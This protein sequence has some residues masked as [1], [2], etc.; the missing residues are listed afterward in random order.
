VGA[1]AKIDT[2]GFVASTLNLSNED[3]AAGRLKF[4]NPNTGVAAAVQNYGD[5]TTATGGQVYLVGGNVENHGLITAPNGD[6]LLAAG[7]SVQIGD[8][9][10]PGVSIQVS[11]NETAANLGS[12]VAQSGKIG[13]VGALV[14]NS[15]RINADQVVHGADGKVYLKAKKD[16]T[17]EATSNIS[18][19][20]DQGGQIT[21]Q[22]EG[23]TA[24]VSGTV[25]AKGSNGTGGSI[26]ALGE[27]VGLTGASLNASGT[28]GGGTILMGGDAHGANAD[29]QNATATY[30]GA[31]STLKADATDSG[32]GGKVIVWADGTTRMYGAISARGGVNGGDGGFVETSGKSAL[33]VGLITPDAS[34]PLGTHGTWLLD[35]SDITIIHGTGTGALIAGLFDPLS[36]STIGDTQIN[37]AINSIV[38]PGID[39]IIKTA[40]GSGGSGNITVNSGVAI[41]NSN[42]GSRT[43]TLTADGAITIVNGSSMA[44]SAGNSLNVVLNATGG[45]TISGTINNAGGTTTLTGAAS[46]TGSG[47]IQNGTLLASTLNVSSGTLDTVTLGGTSMTV[48]GTLHVNNSLTLASGLTVTK[49]S[50]YW[51]FYGAGTEHLATTGSATINNPGGY[52]YANTGAAASSTILQIDSGVTLQGYGGLAQYYASD[53]VN[54]GTV[55]ANTAGQ[56][57]YISPGNFTNASGGTLNASAGTITINSSTFTNAGS[58][59][60]SGGTLTIQ[61]GSTATTPNWTNSGTLNLAAGTLNL[62]G[63]FTASALSAGHFTR[64]GGAVNLTGTLDNT[65]STLDIGSGG[66]FT[67]GLGSFSGTIK[68]GIVLSSDG[69]PL[70]SSGTLDGVTLGGTTLTVNGYVYIRNNLTL[71]NGLTVNKDNNSWYFYGPGTEHLATTGTATI[72]N[73]GGYFYANTG[74]DAATTVLQI[75]SGVTLQGYGGLAQYYTSDIVNAGTVLANVAGQTYYL[76]ANNF[77]NASGGTLNA[78]AGTIYVN[79]TTFTNAGS[80]LVSGGTLTIVPGGS[81][82]PNW[83]NTG[84]LNLAAGTLNLGG[85][86]TSAALT[87]G[88]FTRSGGTVNLTGTLDNTSSTL[89]IGSGGLFTG[90]LGTF[91]GSILNGTLI[92]SD[93]TPLTTSYGTLDGVTLGGASLTVNG[94]LYIKN[95]LTLANGLTVTKDNGTWYFYGA[96]TEHL[97][98]TGS[99]TVIDN[100]GY[101]TVNTGGAPSS[102]ILQIDSG[103]TVRGYGGFNQYYTGDIVNAGSI[104]ADVAGQTFYINPT[105][106]TNNAYGGTLNASAGTIYVNPTTFTNAGS[107]LVSGGTLTI[108]PT[109]W[110]NTGTLNL[111]A[112]TLNLGGAF[113]ASALTGGH[114]TRS[115]GAVNLTGTLDNTSS[116]LDIG[117]GGLFTGG[118]G[119]FSGTIRN[120]T[121]ISSDGTPLTSSYGT[122]DG[123]TLGGTSLT[124]NGGLYVKN[125]MTLASG[126][127]VTKDNGTWYFYGGGTEHVATAGTATI[128]NNGGYFYANVDGNPASTVL[129]I[130]SG[131]TLQG[132]GGL[133]EYYTSD[134]VNAGTIISNAASQTFYISPNNFNVP[135]LV[136]LVA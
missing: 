121:L 47:V 93:G 135:L 29:V 100:G 74:A 81:T 108:T 25:E 85:T 96:G 91:S 113:T 109:N 89:D 122:L 78:S 79:P 42:G 38:A 101:F 30:V 131:I 44:G 125:N 68:N 129:Q 23:G 128:N 90:G 3:F 31:D 136:R 127:T 73:S 35:P 114:F 45:S 27:F 50:S 116:T 83:T 66:L 82:P 18:A 2:A 76:S 130:D 110:T 5:I 15:G 75:D 53:I 117:A 88:H 21:V 120:G 22:A 94:G 10:T 77:T 115:G 84:T 59:L 54:A 49:D 39:V 61:P 65:S 63:T 92:S 67:G 105:N 123:V 41:L 33:D 69:T 95:N 37:N 124:V 56:T 55:L 103:V 28:S 126:L 14:K 102:T 60:V 62:G 1:G 24:M 4:T 6:I 16:I 7:S 32:N 72:N 9:S 99:A 58:A 36:T 97:A 86:F 51:Y 134:I 52:F 43:L 8:T 106:F 111:A 71:A 80:A 11:A 112:G 107:A 40:S 13:L 20:G 19:N 133:S 119:T 104:V 132:Y 57:Y 87:G 118:L 98:T 64:S 48:N 17:L 12:L 46:L 26:Q 70:T 34:A